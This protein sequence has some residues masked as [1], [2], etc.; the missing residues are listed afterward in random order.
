MNR[1]CAHFAEKIDSLEKNNGY[2]HAYMNLKN[3]RDSR[4]TAFQ[5]CTYC[6]ASFIPYIILYCN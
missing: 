1:H 4:G 3:K 5:Q 2:L 6:Y